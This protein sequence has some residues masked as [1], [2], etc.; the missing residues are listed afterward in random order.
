MAEASVAKRSAPST[1]PKNSRLLPVA[2]LTRVVIRTALPTV[3][4]G[5]NVMV[6]ASQVPNTRSSLATVTGTP[7]TF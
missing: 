5:V 2:S 7:P 3:G 1:R 6:L 4:E